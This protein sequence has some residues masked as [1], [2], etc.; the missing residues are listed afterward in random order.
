MAAGVYVYTTLGL[1]CPNI[2]RY[3]ER[4]EIIRFKKSYYPSVLIEVP[5]INKLEIYL[6]PMTTLTF[7]IEFS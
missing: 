7:L 6:H 5:Y 1:L 2:V 4:F 3:I